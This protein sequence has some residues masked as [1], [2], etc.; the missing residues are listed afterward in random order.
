MVGRRRRK[1]ARIGKKERLAVTDRTQPPTVINRRAA[2]RSIPL[3]RTSCRALSTVR[4]R[5]AGYT[6]AWYADILAVIYISDWLPVK[7]IR[8]NAEIPDTRS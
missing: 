6:R 1:F 5:G 8:K 2:R 3:L 4:K 7:I